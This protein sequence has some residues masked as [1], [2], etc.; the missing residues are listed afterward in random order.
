MDKH[1][2]LIIAHKFDYTLK[3]LL[4]VI[5]DTRNDI[6]IHMDKKCKNFN[7][8]DIINM[9]LYSN[10][11]FVD[12]TSVSWG[13]YSLVNAKILLLK[14]A[15][16]NNK[17]QYY[18]FLSGQDLP[19]KNQ[20]HIHNFFNKNNGYEFINFESSVFNYYDRVKYIYPF[21]EKAGKK[22]NIFRFFEL[23][24]LNIQKIINFT[25]PF[26]KNIKFQ[27][28][29]NWCSITDSFARYVISNEKW[30]KKVF[31]KSFICDELIF[32]TLIIN[33][34]FNEKIFD[35]NF[36]DNMVSNMRYIDWNR[37][38][39]YVWK[40]EDYNELINSNVLFAR[41][42]DSEIDREIIDKIIETITKNK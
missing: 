39:P 14:Y 37:G 28:G 1:A 4:T 40:K 25:N 26:I 20:D 12:R 6:Y 33:S 31:S 21:R 13:A 32:Q 34:S 36:D 9:L 15:C 11:Y 3:K 30:L 23:F 7:T 42:F 38:N 27:K 22:K 8:N 24:F 29:S 10:V 2:Y 35:K 19:I 17:Y 41:K 5:D 18:H 16:S